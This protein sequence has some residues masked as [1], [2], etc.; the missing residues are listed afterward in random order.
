MRFIATKDI[1]M[2]KRKDAELAAT[3]PQKFGIRKTRREFQKTQAH[4]EKE[5][6]NIISE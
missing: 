5:T 1:K 2:V 4:I 6:K 3:R